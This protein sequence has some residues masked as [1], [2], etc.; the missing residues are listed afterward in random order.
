MK[1]AGK[2]MSFQ[3]GDKKCTILEFFEESVPWLYG[4]ALRRR[5]IS[6]NASMDDEAFEYLWRY[7]EDI[8][9]DVCDRLFMFPD[10]LDSDGFVKSMWLV[11]PPEEEERWEIFLQPLRSR[12]PRYI[13]PVL[14]RFD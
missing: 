5:G 11:A 8:S 14:V 9:V 12:W 1:R 10:T 6:S 13:K 2:S 3:L 7:R 4:L